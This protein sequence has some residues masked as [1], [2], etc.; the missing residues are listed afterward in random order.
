MGFDIKKNII[1]WKYHKENCM[2]MMDETAKQISKS[3]S[4]NISY[5]AK[6]NFY[7]SLIE[8]TNEQTTQDELV[9][10]LNDMEENPT[11]PE[12]V[13]DRDYYLEQ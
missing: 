11:I 9:V 4:S 2:K 1:K 13:V 3:P 8:R 5:F 6:L 12:T 7:N 10:I